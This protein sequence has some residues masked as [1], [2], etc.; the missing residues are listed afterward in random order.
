VINSPTRLRPAL[1][2]LDCTP[3]PRLLCGRKGVEGAAWSSTR[4]DAPVETDTAEQRIESAMRYVAR[5]RTG[6][7]PRAVELSPDEDLFAGPRSLAAKQ[8]AVRLIQSI[9]AT[10]TAVAL[11]TRGGFDDARGLAEVARRFPGQLTIRIGLFSLD[12]D[13]NARWESGLSGPK[14][15][16]GLAQALADHANV[17]V[18]VGP[19]IPFV[20]AERGQLEAVLRAVAK[21][22]IET[23]SLR[24]VAGGDPLYRQVAREVSR[25]AGRMLRGWLHQPGSLYPGGRRG[26]APQVRGARQG[27]ATVLAGPLGIRFQECPCLD[28]G[29]ERPCVM[30]KTQPPRVFDQLSLALTS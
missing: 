6:R 20:N 29:A 8:A 16:L 1:E 17:S 25:S 21:V 15:R 4:A 27:D 7:G 2:R 9:L 23:V 22:G 10:G 24:W 14:T 26:L 12:P 30:V 5:W 19:L 18:E 3:L 11:T 13:T 28:H